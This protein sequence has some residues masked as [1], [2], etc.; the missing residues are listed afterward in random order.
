MASTETVMW[1]WED[2]ADKLHG[3]SY[4]TVLREMKLGRWPQ[5]VR[6]SPATP[7]MWRADQVQRKLD[8]IMAPLDQA[9]AS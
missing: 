7:L 8:T 3:V 5:A 4:R 9:V 1:R 6:F 2:F